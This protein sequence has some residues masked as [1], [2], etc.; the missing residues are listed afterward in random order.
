M[1]HGGNFSYNLQRNVDENIARQVAVCV[2][3]SATLRNVE[4]YF[5]FPATCNAIFRCETGCAIST[6]TCLPTVVR[7]ELPHVT[8][9]AFSFGRSREVNAQPFHH[10]TLEKGHFK[11]IRYRVFLGL[12]RSVLVYQLT[13]LLSSFV[14]FIASSKHSETCLFSSAFDMSSFCK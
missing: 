3:H 2:L 11:Y 13:W 6:P 12:F 5:T 9:T 8:A 14:S 4:D 10:L 7:C 1:L